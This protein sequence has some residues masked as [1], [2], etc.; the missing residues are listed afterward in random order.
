MGRWLTENIDIFFAKIDLYKRHV[1]KA[2][3]SRLLQKALDLG[4]HS[5]PQSQHEKPP[6]TE[7]R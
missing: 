4:I 7:T 3:I 5:A 1:Y 6:E 2:L